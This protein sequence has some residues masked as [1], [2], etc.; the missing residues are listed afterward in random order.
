MMWCFFSLFKVVEID[1]CLNCVVIWFD[2]GEFEKIYENYLM[3]KECEMLC[4][5]MVN[6]Y[7]FI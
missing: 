3:L 2:Y 7:G 5:D 1:E 4:I 6:N